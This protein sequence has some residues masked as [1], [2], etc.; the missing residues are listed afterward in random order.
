MHLALRLQPRQRA[1]QARV[2]GSSAPV[3]ENRS[4]GSD[5][6]G[7]AP[8]FSENFV[9]FTSTRVSRPAGTAQIRPG[10]KLHTW[11]S[12]DAV[13]VSC[14]R[15]QYKYMYEAVSNMYRCARRRAPSSLGA[16]V[17]PTLSQPSTPAARNSAMF[18]TVPSLAITC[19]MP[20]TPHAASRQ[21]VPGL[22]RLCSGVCA[23]SDSYRITCLVHMT[24]MSADLLESASAHAARASTGKTEQ[25]WHLTAD[26]VCAEW[27]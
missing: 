11:R 15:T 24:Y 21:A 17:P 3:G 13:W 16:T 7:S 23:A 1:R 27:P 14:T 6:A 19:V 20:C 8:S 22:I 9:N 18:C 5:S 10:Q 25:P 4:S 12:P 26:G 2:P